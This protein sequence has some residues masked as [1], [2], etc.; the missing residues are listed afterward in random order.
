[1]IN[2]NYL[3]LTGT[4]CYTQNIEGKDYYVSLYLGEENVRPAYDFMLSMNELAERIP[5][6]VTYCLKANGAGQADICVTEYLA[7]DGATLIQLKHLHLTVEELHDREP[8]SMYHSIPILSY[9]E[10]MRVIES[11]GQHMPL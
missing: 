9:D 2:M 3:Y 11:K 5:G 6:V 10:F 1:M 7:Q 4:F 8:E